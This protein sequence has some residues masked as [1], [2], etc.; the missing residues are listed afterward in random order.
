MRLCRLCRAAFIR[1]H[2]WFPFFVNSTA[3]FRFKAV[4]LKIVLKSGVFI[5]N[6][7]ARLETLEFKLQLV[8]R[9]ELFSNQAKA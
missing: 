3:G 9:V 7:R 5:A 4:R 1:V 6:I 8:R 2:Q